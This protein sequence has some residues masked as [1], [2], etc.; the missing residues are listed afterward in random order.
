VN[1]SNNKL[2]VNLFGESFRLMKIIVEKEK[3][4][5]W[6]EIAARLHKPLEE[7]LT[8]PFFYHY[9][10]NKKVKS[11]EDIT[12]VITEG[13]IN[14]SKNQIEIWYQGKKVQKLKIDELDSSLLLFPLYT[15]SLAKIVGNLQSGIYVEQKEIGL[16]GSFEISEI[17]NFN[18]ENLEFKLVEYKEK[19]LVNQLEYQKQPLKLK[20]KDTIVIYQN[21]FKID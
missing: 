1:Y 9:L 10:N 4:S 12:E 6:S 19:L 7:A 14:N 15:F 11:I 18:I 2:K 17:S 5:H 13:L 16:Y 3:E 8:D 21:G 20:K